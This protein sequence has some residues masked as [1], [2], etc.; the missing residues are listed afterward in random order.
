[1]RGSDKEMENVYVPQIHIMAEKSIYL[2]YAEN[3][4][5]KPY[6]QVVQSCF[7]IISV[8]E[9]RLSTFRIYLKTSISRHANFNDIMTA[10]LG[11]R[12]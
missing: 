5:L 9:E 4:A 8:A 3:D 10:L 11:W 12:N 2:T 6:V 1:M 7:Q